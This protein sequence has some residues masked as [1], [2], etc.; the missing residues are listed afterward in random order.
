MDLL[1]IMELFLIK[2]HV[3]HIWRRDAGKV[4]RSVHIVRVNND[5]IR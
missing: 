5:G 1:K 2:R 4:N 3:S